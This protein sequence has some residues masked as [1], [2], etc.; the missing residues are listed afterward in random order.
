M[1]LLQIDDRQL[2]SIQLARLTQQGPVVVTH[3][4]VP[5]FVAH[6][7]TREWLEALAAEE[8][9]SGEM[10]LHEYAEQYEIDL[11]AEAYRREFPEDAPFTYPPKNQSHS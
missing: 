1:S 3:D 5:V 7:A 10:T 11:D 2:D 4:G 9:R 6:L 8:G